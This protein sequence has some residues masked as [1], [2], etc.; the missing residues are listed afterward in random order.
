LQSPKNLQNSS[1]ASPQVPY[2]HVRI[3]CEA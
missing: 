1:G 3:C 2:T